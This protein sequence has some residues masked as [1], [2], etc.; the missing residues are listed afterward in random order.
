MTSVIPSTFD[1]FF[2]QATAEMEP[3]PYQE[4]IAER[5]GLPNLL[6]VP[7]GMGKTE[8]V[9]LGWLWRRRF[10]DQGTRE[11]TPRRL[12]YCLPMRVLVEQTRDKA[13]LWL[14]RL[15]LL[16]G[17]AE[18]EGEAGKEN[19]KSYAP[20]WKRAGQV[21]VTVLMGGEEQDDWDHYPERDAIIIGTQDMLISRALNRGY[22]LSRAR[23][24]MQ[25]GLLHTDC[26]WIF[27]EVQLMGPGL[28]TTA[29]LEAFR[30]LL[31]SKDG[32]GS[33]SVWMS[34]TMQREWL[35]T[36]D[37]KDRAETFSVTSLEQDDYQDR[38]VKKRFGAIKPLAKAQSVIGDAPGLASEVLREH[39]RGRGTRTIVVLNT[40]RR[41]RDLAKAMR[42]A[43]ASEAAARGSSPELILLHSRFRPSDRQKA[44]KEAISPID[45]DG[46]GTIV[47][48]TQVIEAG[49]DVS[50][51]ML[52][53]ELAPWASLVQRF[54][55]CNRTGNENDT[56]RVFWIDLPD[57]EDPDRA[58]PYELDQ[59]AEARA[60]LEDCERGVGPSHLPRVSLPCRHTHVIRRKDLIELFDTTPDLAGNDIDIDRFVRD[61]D[62][63][64][65][66]VYW[67][68]WS[69]PKE[70]A[71][72]PKDEPPP[73]REELCSAAIGGHGNPGFRDFAERNRAKVWRW[74]FLEKKW[75]TAVATRVAPGQVFLI[76]PNAGGYTVEDG[77]D[78]RSEAYV[79]PIPDPSE[80]SIAA[81]D[82]NDEDSPS[83]LN[84]WQTIAEHAD[85][86]CRE[87][88]AVL[89]E[90]PLGDG[91]AQA[92]RVGA[93]WH[94]RG[95]A[96]PVFQNAV[97]DGGIVSREGRSVSRLLRPERWRGCRDIAK[98]PGKVWKD[99]KVVHSGWWRRYDWSPIDGRK[100]FRHELASALAVLDP[101]NKA[102][103]EETR[104]LIAYLIAAHHGKVRLSIRS[105]PEERRPEPAYDDHGEGRRFARGVWEGD[106]LPATDLGGGVSAPAA[107]I[108]L[109]PM[110]L[111][112]CVRTPFA[113][114]LSWIERIIRLRDG[115][116]P[117]RLTYL[118]ALLRAADWRASAK[119]AAR[120]ASSSEEAAHG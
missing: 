84:V 100:H 91:L 28:A 29:Q 33:R 105:L 38:E 107:T 97:D 101:R 13:V 77:W 36:V 57:R 11:T 68:E 114:Q 63:S 3:F 81:Q 51:T 16:G 32:H 80:G 74:N 37:F 111:G 95:K 14:H 64:D 115:H 31:G 71:P 60:H 93:R 98:A 116:G 72:P 41:A 83:R 46:P 118:E 70:G 8:S 20:A 113:G 26:L 35:A 1:E 102:I 18:L 30:H 19:V 23:W 73:R 52:F 53:T 6:H 40:I 15:Q 110:E 104:D 58:L 66:H 76:H 17:K 69:L 90:I 10:A 103:P 48:S 4:R 109:E 117:F 34:A 87:L 67:R 96:H 45:S 5:P 119:A 108:S 61:V 59:V 2:R 75:E 112:L 89:V 92:L 9:V 94:D 27:D 82:A 54:G 79:K 56:A 47:V 88:D 86:T 24:P 62:S 22:A 12:V 50:A 21:A 44:I 25:F 78:E 106:A 39:Q 43:L 120:G 65:V 99:G 42:K 55:R 7:T 85:D 49:V